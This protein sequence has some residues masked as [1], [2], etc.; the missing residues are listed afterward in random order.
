MFAATSSLRK[1]YCKS[2]V[3]AEASGKHEHVCVWGYLGVCNHDGARA[4]STKASPR[5]YEDTPIA[6]QPET[7]MRERVQE[8]RLNRK[9]QRRQDDARYKNQEDNRVKG[10]EGIR[11]S[12]YD[13]VEGVSEGLDELEHSSQAQYSEHFKARDVLVYG[14]HNYAA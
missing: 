5:Q 11:E 6:M 14:L 13:Q 7:Y 8:S 9:H 2:L 4:H 1:L 12:C 3:N 10:C